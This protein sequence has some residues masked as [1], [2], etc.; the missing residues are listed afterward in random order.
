MTN[1]QQDMQQTPQ[2]GR[3]VIYTRP[4]RSQAAAKRKTEKE[5]N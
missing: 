5:D 1:N 4:G 2:E 3:A